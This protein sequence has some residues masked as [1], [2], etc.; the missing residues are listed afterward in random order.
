[1]GIPVKRFF[2]G[3]L[4]ALL[5]TIL[6]LWIVVA[7]YGFIADYVAA[8]VT[9]MI[10]WSLVSNQVGHEL[11]EAATP[12]SVFDERFIDPEAL[13]DGESVSEAVASSRRSSG[14]FLDLSRVDREKLYSALSE[15]IPPVFGLTIGM[16][17]IFLAGCLLRGF[18]G[19]WLFAR[20][21]RFLSSFPVVRSIYPW[22]K[23]IVD[24]FFREKK[25]LREFQTV[26]AVP[27]PRAGMF[28]LGFVTNDGL[29]S[30]N[31]Q[32]D[33][34]FVAVF[35][36]SSPTPMTGYVCFVEKSDVV[37]LTISLDQVM[38]LLV[39]GGVI[40]PEDELVNPVDVKRLRAA[41]SDPEGDS[42]ATPQGVDGAPSLTA[43]KS[44]EPRAAD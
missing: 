15:R 36:P 34:E 2:V 6:T 8:P 28:T 26:V 7:L 41:T 17:L 1:M 20:G 21:E 43:S 14:F 35:L 31:A 44:S 12:L 27:Y 30:L 37:P 4:A 40:V 22:A 19:R 5:P 39:S 33:G 38:G 13:V 23:Q 18:A 9:R 16:I 25:Q 3:G 42:R 32:Q 11:L 24:F 29:Q 10:H